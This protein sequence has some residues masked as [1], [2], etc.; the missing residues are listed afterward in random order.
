MLNKEE[1]ELRKTQIGA[2]DIHKIF[3][4]D[5]KGAKDLWK[6]KVGLLEKEEFT[7]QYLVAGNLLEEDCLTYYFKKNNIKGYELNKR[8]EH[9]KIKNFVVSLDANIGNIP[10]ENKTINSR[11]FAKLTKVSRRYYLQLQAQMSCL[12]SDYGYIIY[13]SVTPEDL[14]EPLNYQPSELTQ[15]VIRV[16]RNIEVIAEIENRVEYFLWCVQYNREPEEAHYISRM[17]F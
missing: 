16:E 9:N 6:E 15:E 8:V 13:N 7:N 12:N 17:V 14:E 4:F 2:S 10:Y 11:D 5:N 1:R 3:N